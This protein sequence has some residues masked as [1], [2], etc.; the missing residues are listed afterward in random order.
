MLDYQYVDH[1][2]EIVNHDRDYNNVDVRKEAILHFSMLS[3]KTEEVPNKNY[4]DDKEKKK[5]SAIFIK[6]D[7][8]SFLLN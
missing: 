8:N 3:N 2:T 7:V 1:R 6:R 4:A 5:T